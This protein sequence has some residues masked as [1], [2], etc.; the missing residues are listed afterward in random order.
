M[1]PDSCR[2]SFHVC[3]ALDPR[4]RKRIGKSDPTQLSYHIPNRKSTANRPPAVKICALHKN[5]SFHLWNIPS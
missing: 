3:P 2:G 1:T 4:K 5:T